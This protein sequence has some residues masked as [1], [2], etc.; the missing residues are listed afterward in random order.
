MAAGGHGDGYGARALEGEARAGDAAELEEL[1]W[2]VGDAEAP[3]PDRE[4]GANGA[5]VERA[6]GGQRPATVVVE[7]AGVLGLELTAQERVPVDARVD[8]RVGLVVVGHAFVGE[9]QLHVGVH[10][11]DDDLERLGA[12]VLQ[13][14]GPAG[15]GVVVEAL[16]VEGLFVAVPGP[17]VLVG[18]VAPAPV[19]KRPVRKDPELVERIDALLADR[20][21]VR[22]V[23]A[24]V[25]HVHELLPG[26]KPGERR[27]A[28]VE[29]RPR[30]LPV[31]V[32]RR[33][34][35][36]VG[37]R[38]VVQMRPVP[39]GEGVVDRLGQ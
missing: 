5:V 12:G 3:V 16:D 13:V 7:Q 25:E 17:A 1:G 29:R 2:L 23:V 33:Q 28:I 24:E 21:Q 14:L 39:A 4:V 32:R 15:D 8:P 6:R 31:D 37:E 30:V 10:G 26:P 9:G 35:R 22:P 18:D 20:A 19:G 36:P 11:D 27:L 38:E 34:P